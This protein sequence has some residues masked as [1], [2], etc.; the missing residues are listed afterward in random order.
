MAN[1]LKNLIKIL[2]DNLK[3]I[4]TGMISILM[5]LSAAVVVSLY[6]GGDT[7]RQLIVT[8]ITGSAFFTRDGRRIPVSKNTRLKSGDILETA[9]GATVR[10][11]IDDDKFVFAEPN[12]S[13]YIYCTDIASK[14]DIAVNLSRG[15]VICEINKEL[16]KKSS[17]VLKTPNSSAT[18]TGTVFRAKFDVKNNFMDYSNVMVTEY[19]NFDGTVNLQLYDS[20]G[21]PFELPM[22]LV[23][24]TSAQMIT[25][26]DVCKYGYLNYDISLISLNQTTLHEILRAQNAKEIGFSP[27]EIN[28]AYKSAVEESRRLE[29]MTDTTVMPTEETTV[30]TT[31]TTA[32]P[33]E[34]E[35]SP[36]ETTVPEETTYGTL[37]STQRTYEYTTYSGVK[38]WEFTGNTNFDTAGFEDWFDPDAEDENGPVSA[39]PSQAVQNERSETVQIN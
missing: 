2:S 6:F 8:E 36:S 15:S 29:T 33:T 4:L 35:T 16:G 22:V 38:W 9:D 13:M 26:E 7:T 19:Q 23:E 12:T 31:T 32:A 20:K 39:V 28:L 11:S 1:I 14:G 37:R 18:V 34:T 30:T 21:E 3:L 27:E 25:S 24:R 5:I 10:I 17:F